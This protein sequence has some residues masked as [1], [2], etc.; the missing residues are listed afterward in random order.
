MLRVNLYFSLGGL[1][2]DF[3]SSFTLLRLVL[4]FIM[5]G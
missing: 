4:N 1:L 3:V 2:L 5:G